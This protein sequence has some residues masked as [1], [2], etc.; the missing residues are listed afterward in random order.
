MTRFDERSGNLY[1]TELGRVASHYY[2]RHASIVAFSELLKPRMSEAD[3]RR[4]GPRRPP[5]P[6]AACATVAAH[7]VKV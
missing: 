5:P 7:T 1:V 2:I 6:A 4:A 3:V